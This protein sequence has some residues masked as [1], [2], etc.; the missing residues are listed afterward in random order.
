MSINKTDIQYNW[1]VNDIYSNWEEWQKDFDKIVTLMDEISQLKGS[2]KDATSLIKILDLNEKLSILSYKIYRYPQ[3]QRDIN[4][5]DDFLN[6]KFQEVGIL[7][8]KFSVATSWLTPEM[9]TIPQDT[10]K[11]WIE[12]NPEKL[13]KHRFSL[14]NMYRLQKHVL[15]EEKEKLLSYYSQF[16]NT[17]QDIYTALSVTD[18]EFPIIKLSDNSEIKLTRGKYNKILNTNRNRED[19][20]KSYENFNKI[21]LKNKNTYA[22]IYKSILLRGVASAKSR[23]YNST[24]EG[25]LEGNNIPVAVYE[26]L[27]NSVK[28]NTKPLKKYRELRK[29]ALKIDDYRPWDSYISL[30]DYDNKY[31]YEKAKE[32]VLK[33]LYSMDSEYI[34][35]AKKALN[36]RWI[37]VYE[38]EGKRSGAYSAGTYGVHPYMLLNYNGTLDSVFT[39]A[40]ELGHT[41]HTLLSDENQPFATHNYTIF[42]AEVASTYNE[43]LLLEYML[44][45]SDDPKEKIAL[46][47]QAINNIVGTFF[48]QVM[49]ADFEYQAHK[50]AEN[51]TPITAEILDN[52]VENLLNNYYGED[53][54]KDEYSNIFWTRIPHFYNS[55]YYVYQYA[56]CFASSSK[57][58]NNIKSNP[59]NLDT[60]IELLKSGGNDF[61]IE[62]LKKSGVDL[63]KKET[64]LKVINEL[65]ELVDEL[66]K[67][68]KEN[69]MI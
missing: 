59:K 45:T 32:L 23:N 64:I 17:P 12:E 14:M 37:D 24:L 18:I 46:L 55:P 21:F 4:S 26:T 65:D 48:T 30:V 16:R 38:K 39:L 1:N 58:Y 13:E 61:P 41:M 2:I 29:K 47:E 6:K 60:Y 8:S 54:Y 69:N 35:K 10:M 44:K 7:F 56:T 68:L 3:L 42:V 53:R 15:D 51:N 50:L 9:L 11:K 31:D 20:K 22:A 27:I 33:S 52:I 43:K 63:T 57:I 36:N 49:F 34:K 25:A 67:V 62:Q 28:E 19:R 66:E 5:K 40:H